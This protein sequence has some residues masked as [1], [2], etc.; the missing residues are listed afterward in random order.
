MNISLSTFAPE[1][2]E[3]GSAVPSRVDLPVSI[4][5]M[6]L[7][8]TNEIPPKFRGGVHLFF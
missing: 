3:T 4:L 6:N 2:R 8:L 7:V 5:K 1:N